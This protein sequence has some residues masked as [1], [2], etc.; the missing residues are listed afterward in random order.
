MDARDI[1]SHLLASSFFRSFARGDEALGPLLDAGRYTALPAPL[2]DLRARYG[3]GVGTGAVV[4]VFRHP[5]TAHEDRVYYFVLDP[6]RGVLDGFAARLPAAA[7]APAPLG[8]LPD[9]EPGV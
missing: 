3:P 7:T 8:A 9:R 2:A 1:R 6:S 4:L 5:A